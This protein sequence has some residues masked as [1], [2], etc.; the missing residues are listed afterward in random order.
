MSH[1]KESNPGAD[2]CDYTWRSLG[3]PEEKNNHSWTFLN[4]LKVHCCW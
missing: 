4:F 1:R 2:L 3:C